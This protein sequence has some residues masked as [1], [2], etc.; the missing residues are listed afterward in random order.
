MT[1]LVKPARGTARLERKARKAQ[2]KQQEDE[3]IAA[4]KK[5]DHR[6]CRWPRKHECRGGLEGAHVFKHRGM[7]GNPAGDLTTRATILTVCAEIHRLGPE[8]IDGKQ[9]KVV[10][11]T[12]CGT[13]GILSFWRKNGDG[14]YY[15]VDIECAI[16]VVEP[17]R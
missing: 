6:R 12:P 9:L 2:A 14:E 17:H 3:A 11:E 7:G 16:G 13:D 5:R 1:L 15:R 8:S 4:A 10:A